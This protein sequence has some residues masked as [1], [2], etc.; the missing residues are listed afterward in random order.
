MADG[1]IVDKWGGGIL[2]E[3]ITEDGVETN[4][5]TGWGKRVGYVNEVNLDGLR[6][7]LN[8]VYIPA[9]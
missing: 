3:D 2:I 1:D 8:K 5:V 9:E 4:G 6:I 7:V